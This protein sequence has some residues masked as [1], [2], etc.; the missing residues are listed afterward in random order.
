MIEQT[1]SLSVFRVRD[2]FGEKLV[3]VQ[4]EHHKDSVSEFSRVMKKCIFQYWPL[5]HS[6]LELIQQ[7]I[8]ELIDRLYVDEYLRYKILRQEVLL[9][10]INDQS[11]VEH[12]R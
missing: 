5:E 9:S 3:S 10:I 11:Q 7:E 4:L 12:L 1:T 6:L 8:M 2:Y